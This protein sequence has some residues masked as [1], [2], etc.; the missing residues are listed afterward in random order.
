MEKANSRFLYVTELNAVL[1]NALVLAQEPLY[2]RNP[3]LVNAYSTTNNGS[4]RRGFLLLSH[5]T[6][7]P[8]ALDMALHEVTKLDRDTSVLNSTVGQV[9]FRTKPESAV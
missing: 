8:Q 7:L 5:P 9:E 2:F 4:S 6:C 1:M 3:V